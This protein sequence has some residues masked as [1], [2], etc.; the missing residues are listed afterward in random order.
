MSKISGFTEFWTQFNALAWKNAKLKIRLWGTLLL[1]LLIPTF[2]IVALGVLT[3]TLPSSNF[4]L[5]IP[6]GFTS[7]SSFN[8]HARSIPSFRLNDPQNLFGQGSCSDYSTIVWNCKQRVSCQSLNFT[9]S[10][11][12]LS[13]SKCQLNKIAVAPA[14]ATD[15]A[16]VNAAKGFAAWI[17]NNNPIYRSVNNTFRYFPSESD[18]VNYITQP[19][20]A[21]DPSIQVFS[22]AVIISGGYPTWSYS[23]RMNQTYMM[24]SSLYS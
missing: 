15:A 18:F 12:A 23:L 21:I 1:E 2:I 3:R 4:E 13:K 6:S 5:L 17:N 10:F 7:P 8:T 19:N 20:Y 9:G 16:S 14:S 22:A 24:V 11:N